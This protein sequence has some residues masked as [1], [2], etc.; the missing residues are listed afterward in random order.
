MSS[1]GRTYSRSPRCVSAILSRRGAFTSAPTP[2]TKTRAPLPSEA[3]ATFF[4]IASGSVVPIVG[5]PSVRKT[6]WNVRFASASPR[7]LSAETSASSRA[8]PPR[9]FKALMYSSASFLL[10]SFAAQRLSLKNRTSVEK[11]IRPKR[12]WG[13]S[14]C[15]Q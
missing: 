9:A 1:P 12:S 15:T 14:R 5:S 11:S 6:T 10:A 8:V 4:K 3:L 2:K 7:I 13:S